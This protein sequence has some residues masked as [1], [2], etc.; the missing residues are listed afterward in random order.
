M[1][2]Y[3]KFKGTPILPLVGYRLINQDPP[4]GLEMILVPAQRIPANG[5]PFASNFEQS[6]DTLLQSLHA[7]AVSD[8]SDVTAAEAPN[9]AEPS[10]LVSPTCPDTSAAELAKLKEIEEEGLLSLGWQLFQDQE[11]AA[12]KEHKQDPRSNEYDYLLKFALLGESRCGKTCML[13]RFSD[14]DYTSHYLATIGAAF[15]I[16]V[17]GRRGKTIKIQTWDLSGMRAGLKPKHC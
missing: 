6:F 3:T 2:W 9:E 16:R 14:D 12:R 17:L 7:A 13:E 5:A 8:T 10:P 4:A 1:E 11:H 15:K